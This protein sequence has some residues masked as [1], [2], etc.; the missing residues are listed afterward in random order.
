L[1][2][3]SAENFSDE[4]VPIRSN[5]A[6]NRFTTIKYRY[7]YPLILR[8]APKFDGIGMVLYGTD[9]HWLLFRPQIKQAEAPNPGL[10]PCISL[11][12]IQQIHPIKPFI[13]VT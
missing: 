3:H 6:T 13:S 4:Y 5:R 2:R 7:F 12:A 9:F 1:K 10:F 8:A 11:P